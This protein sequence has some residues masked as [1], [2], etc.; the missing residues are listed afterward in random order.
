VKRIIL[1]TCNW[2]GYSGIEEAG[3]QKK[4]YSP[5]IYPIRV[6]CIGRITPGIILK[7]F[8]KG[9]DGVYLLGCSE[10]DCHYQTGNQHVEKVFDESHNLLNLLGYKRNQLKLGLISAGDSETFVK[11]M[12]NFDM[13]IED[14][15]ESI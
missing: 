12:Q 14:L 2:N 9:A 5:D 15:Q 6:S 3:A 7:A 13:E 10:N 11:E 8:E 4:S 1:F